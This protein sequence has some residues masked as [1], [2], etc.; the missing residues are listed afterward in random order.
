[1]QLCS[2]CLTKFFL[3]AFCDH[4]EAVP[5]SPGWSYFALDRCQEP[6]REGRSEHCA[7][8]CC[9]ACFGESGEVVMCAYIANRHAMC[10]EPSYTRVYVHDFAGK[11]GTILVIEERAP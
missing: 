9:P 7:W 4:T 5:G 6:L 11:S 8:L 1:M 2:D 10:P 3:C